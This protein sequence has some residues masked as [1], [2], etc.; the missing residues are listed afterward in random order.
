MAQVRVEMLRADHPD[1]ARLLVAYLDEIKKA[2]GGFDPKRSPSANPDE[3]APPDGMFLV[4]Y[5]DDVAVGCGGVKTLAPGVGEVKR[6]FIDPKARGRGYG[7]RLLL[8]LEA[9]ARSLGMR[10]I[11]LDTSEPLTEAVALYLSSGY[12]QIDPYNDNPF[13][14]RW[15]GKSF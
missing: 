9:A 12:Q 10:R 6:M 2:L 13:A 8:D 7:R 15:F 11:L 5:E 1:G 4:L 3:L 14:T